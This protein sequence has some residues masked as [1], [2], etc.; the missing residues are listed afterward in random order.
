MNKKIGIIAITTLV[1]IAVNLT[2]SNN[3]TLKIKNDNDQSYNLPKVIEPGIHDSFNNTIAFTFGD[4]VYFI[5]TVTNE[6]TYVYKAPNED[7]K[8][9]DISLENG[10]FNIKYYAEEKENLMTYNVTSKL[11]ERSIVSNVE[12]NKLKYN[13]IEY[14]Y[15]FNGNF[16]SLSRLKLLKKKFYIEPGIYFVEEGKVYFS[17]TEIQ[18]SKKVAKGSEGFVTKLNQGYWKIDNIVK[19]N[20]KEVLY[21]N[22]VSNTYIDK[23]LYIYDKTNESISD[24]IYS[25][26]SSYIV[27]ENFDSIIIVPNRNRIINLESDFTLYLDD[28]SYESYTI[29]VGLGNRYPMEILDEKRNEF[30]GVISNKYFTFNFENK[31]INELYDIEYNEDTVVEYDATGRV[32]VNGNL[33]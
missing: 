10:M 27:S 6:I 29:D 25:P 8:L 14:D 3:K 4:L 33:Y 11:E 17:K 19:H 13:N 24:K 31:I 9:V 5:D 7:C 12:F 18:S 1:M 23:S 30:I 16:I 21:A 2:H 28:G 22:L 15:K 32:S 26:F 20:K